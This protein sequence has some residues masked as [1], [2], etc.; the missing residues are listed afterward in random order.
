MFAPAWALEFC[1]CVL[2]PVVSLCG[3]WVGAGAR[4]PQSWT[5]EAV[6]ELMDALPE[7]RLQHLDLAANALAV[8]A[9]AADGR[10]AELRWRNQA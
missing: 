5:A 9:S 6:Q 3:G 2:G 8:P 1:L 4:E 10:Q 7:S